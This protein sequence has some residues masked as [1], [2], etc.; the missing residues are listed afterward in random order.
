MPPNVGTGRKFYSKVTVLGAGSFGTA[1]AMSAARNNHNVVFYCRDPVQ[2][3][4]INTKHVNNEFH[5]SFT[6]PNNITATTDLVA[7]LKDTDMIIHALPCQLSP[8][9]FAENAHLIPPSV[10]IC[11]T[12]KGLYVETKQLLGDAILSALKRPQVRGERNE[13]RRG[14]GLLVCPTILLLPRTRT[15]TH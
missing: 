10:C 1:M 7:A 4:S 5:C 2:A 13:A 15:R 12:A 6:L 3:E 14:E 11:S 9:F 8:K